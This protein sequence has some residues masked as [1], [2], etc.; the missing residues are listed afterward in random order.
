MT[1][2]AEAAYTATAVK[3]GQFV[4][5]HSRDGKISLALVLEAPAD[6]GGSNAL[7]LEI[8]RANGRI[9]LYLREDVPELGSPVCH[10]RVMQAME[11]A[12]VSAATES[13][14]ATDLADPASDAPAAAEAAAAAVSGLAG[15]DYPVRW[16]MPLS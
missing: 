9:S 12:M 4:Q 6:P 3:P 8:H 11:Q 15:P 10:A 1:A 16:W 7:A 13:I 14:E 5:Y 2:T